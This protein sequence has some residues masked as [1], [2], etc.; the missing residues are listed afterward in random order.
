MLDRVSNSFNLGLE[1]ISR[2]LFNLKW[3]IDLLKTIILKT[4]LH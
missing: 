2:Y 1:L 3:S 4:A